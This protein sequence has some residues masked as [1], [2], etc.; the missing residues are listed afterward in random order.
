M[1]MSEII[2]RN[3]IDGRKILGFVE[4]IEAQ[5]KIK[6]GASEQIKIVNAEAKALGYSEEGIGVAMKAR[7]MKPSEFREGEDL[8]DLYL[9]VIGLTA[10]PPTVLDALNRPLPSFA[11][12]LDDRNGGERGGDFEHFND[13]AR[14]TQ[15]QTATG[16]R[17]ADAAEA[18]ADAKRKK[19]AKAA[20][21][22]PPA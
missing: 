14:R 6:K 22:S 12:W 1:I 18:M 10:P 8:R 2:G 5:E 13:L 16:H 20:G 19:E 9:S 17:I 11:E 4:R 21:A 3:T 15:D 7:S